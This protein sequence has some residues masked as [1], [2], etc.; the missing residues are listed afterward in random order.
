MS[1]IRILSAL[2]LV[3]LSTTLGAQSSAD[4]VRGRVTDDSSRAIAGATVIIT[5]GPD[6][7]IQQTTTDANG[8]YSSRFEPG[9]GDYLVN[10]AFVGYRTAR[11]RV[12]RL[13]SERELVADFTLAK[14]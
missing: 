11:R 8:V 10:V 4:V 9:T 1:P 5:R 12:Q 6:R 14:D 13:G 3:L 2:C 7:L